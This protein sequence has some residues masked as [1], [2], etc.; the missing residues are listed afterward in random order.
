MSEES[1]IKRITKDSKLEDISVGEKIELIGISKEDQQ[2]QAR[3][4]YYNI[5]AKLMLVSTRES[6]EEIQT[7]FYFFTSYGVKKGK[8]I[9]HIPRNSRNFPIFDKRLLEVGL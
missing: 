7:H 9:T 2:Q 3:V 1:S 4:E 6:T 5:N 8:Q